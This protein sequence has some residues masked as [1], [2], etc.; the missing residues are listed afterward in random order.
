MQA[1][2]Q[3]LCKEQ[4]RARRKKTW[5]KVRIPLIFGILVFAAICCILLWQK[6]QPVPR[7][8]DRLSVSFLDVGQ[9]DSTLIYT[10]D[11]AILIDGG[12]YET[13]NRVTDALSKLHISRLDAVIVTHP[14]ADHIGGLPLVLSEINADA[15]YMSHFPDALVPTGYSFEALLDM[16]EQKQIP[17]VYPNCGDTLTFGDLKFTML[18]TDNSAAADLNDCSLVCRVEYGDTSFLIMGDAAEAE[19]TALLLDGCIAKTNVLRCGHHGSASST[20]DALLAAADPEYAVISVGAF[21]DY[22]HPAESLLKRLFARID[23]VFRTDT[24]GSILAV[25]D[26]HT[27][28]FTTEK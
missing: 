16:A 18:T 26:G 8:A 13:G 4:A 10:A 2:L 9:G 28:H 14:H 12:S 5:R 7:Y 17:I 3:K 15:L 19:D 1:E 22:G 21:N 27:I 6:H 25:S 23:N 20:S 11:A 24:D